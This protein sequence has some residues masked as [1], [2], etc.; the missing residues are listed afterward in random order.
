MQRSARRIVLIHGAAVTA[1]V[2]DGVIAALAASDVS[3]P[4]LAPQRVYSGSLDAE[5]DALAPLCEDALVVGI[6]GGATLGLELASRG[7]PFA[8]AVLHEPAVGSL[9]PGLLAPMA[10]AFESGGVAGFANV[11]YGPSWRPGLA[12]SD[13]DAVARDLAMFRGFEP[14]PAADGAGPVLITV[15]ELSP[16]S[17]YDAAA[18]LNREFGYTV[19]ALT[20]SAH[21][22]HLDAVDQLTTLIV[23]LVKRS[24]S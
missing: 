8:C 14:R 22:A 7:V 11:L 20:G 24:T 21:A 18:A 19:Q 16:Q 13:G 10:A 3:V 12:P 15:G 1:E 17:R 6:S 5:V 2:W 4:V 23:E 9:L